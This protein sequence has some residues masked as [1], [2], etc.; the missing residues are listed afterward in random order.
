MEKMKEVVITDSI[1]SIASDRCKISF[2][3]FQKSQRIWRQLLD[4]PLYVARHRPY[5]T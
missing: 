4:Q 2:G 5:D 3:S 1:C